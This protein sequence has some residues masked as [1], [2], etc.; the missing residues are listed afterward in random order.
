MATK[1]SS[2]FTELTEW[3]RKEDDITNLERDSHA[4]FVR[5]SHIDPLRD[6]HIDLVRDSHAD[7]VQDSYADLSRDSHA[8]LART[9]RSDQ[10]YG[11]ER[12]E[13]KKG[14]P[15]AAVDVLRIV[16]FQGTILSEKN[17]SFLCFF[18]FLCS[19]W[20]IEFVSRTV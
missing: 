4:D 19:T 7:P 8:T 20:L 3:S 6:N 10:Y 9:R 1:G 2:E 18:Y 13:L 14:P 17:G 15:T 11:G 12:E 16:A 5:D